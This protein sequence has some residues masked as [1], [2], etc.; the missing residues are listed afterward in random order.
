EGALQETDAARSAGAAP[1]PDDAHHGAHVP[2]APQLAVLLEVDE[3]F[4]RFVCRRVLLRGRGAGTGDGQQCALCGIAAGDGRPALG[5]T[6][7]PWRARYR[8]NSS[9]TVGSASRRE[10]SACASSCP[11]KTRSIPAFLLPSRNSTA[12]YW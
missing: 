6:A 7:W 5:G 3:F 11:S 2:E 1:V 4:A 9:Y 12:R 10:S 8:R